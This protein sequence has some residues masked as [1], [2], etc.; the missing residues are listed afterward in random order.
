MNVSSSESHANGSKRIS[1]WAEFDLKQRRT[2]QG[3]E[4]EVYAEPYPLLGGPTRVES[5]LNKNKGLVEKPFSSVV[6]ASMNFPS[7]TNPDN[8]NSRRSVALSNLSERSCGTSSKDETYHRLEA[9]SPLV[10]ESSI[11]DL[12]AG[13]DNDI[14]ELNYGNDQT[15]FVFQDVPF[16]ERADLSFSTNESFED[17][18]IGCKD[19][20]YFSPLLDLAKSLPIEP[21]TGQEDDDVYL[22]HRKDA[23]KMI[24][25]ASRYSKAANDAYLRG[26]HLSARH[27]SLKA[28]EHWTAAEKLNAK[29][30]KGILATRNSKNDPWTLDLHGLHAMESVLALQ[31]HLRTVESLVSSN[32]LANLSDVS[33][34]SLLL[35]GSLQSLNHVE[36]EKFGM[37]HQPL[38]Q[39]PVLLQVI[40]G[41]GNHSRGAAALPSAIRNFLNENRYQFDETRPG[42]V[43][44]RP[45][46]RQQLAASS[47]QK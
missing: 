22:F 33:Q 15:S 37:Q 23:V 10:D 46:F 14:N 20:A 32:C 47:S 18:N 9:F 2:Q 16:G 6:S 3:L 31:E 8:Q 5:L 11:E 24:R 26:D 38:K 36:K 25:S 29:A 39:R 7:F 40:T 43:T 12:L 42:V 27:F 4:G 21:Q 13:V 45:K 28:K 19:D 41:K 35:P 34:E 30:A 44:I 17:N 1:G